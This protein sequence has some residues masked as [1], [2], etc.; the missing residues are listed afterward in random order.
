MKS[1][2][3]EYFKMVCDYNDIP[4]EK[5]ETLS[6]ASLLDIRNPFGI[7]GIEEFLQ[8]LEESREKKSRIL[9]FGDYD[10]D[11]VCAASILYKALNSVHGGYVSYYNPLYT[12]GYGIQ[13]KHVERFL[14][15][16][17]DVFITVDNGVSAHAAF[18]AISKAGK[19]GA[20]ID[21]H[22]RL[23]T[24]PP[25]SADVIINPSDSILCGAQLAYLVSRAIKKRFLNVDEHDLQD[26]TLAGIAAQS[27]YVKLD[28]PETRSW[29]KWAHYYVNYSNESPAVVKMIKSLKEETFV[30]SDLK[31]VG[32]LLNMA[33]RHTHVDPK[34]IVSATLCETADDPQLKDLK[35]LLQK[36]E[37]V[38][39]KTGSLFDRL[40][41]ETNAE[42]GFVIHKFET[43]SELAEPEGEIAGWLS[44][45]YKCPIILF[46]EHGDYIN[47]Q[48]RS[49]DFFS[50]KKY[51]EEPEIRELAVSIGGHPQ[52]IGGTI[53]ASRMEQ[54]SRKT[55]ELMKKFIPEPIN[56]KSNGKELHLRTITPKE[57]FYL[58][59][60]S[61]P[62]GNAF[63]QPEFKSTLKTKDSRSF[64]NGMRVITGDAAEDGVWDVTY[65]LDE[66]I[67]DGE[68]IGI[69]I[70]Q[71][72]PA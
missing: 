37:W 25:V 4:D 67:C 55:H 32:S 29:V 53:S 7:E 3:K 61:A 57:A 65:K 69:K 24:L 19:K 56:S 64:I 44:S 6:K 70:T 22:L 12:E 34:V 68:Q 43:Y 62:F 42:S 46:R 14:D 72:S 45:H 28:T 71:K 1:N 54:F 48:G 60:K 2:W 51:I 11:G 49:P 16:G 59:R 31:S 13:K 40:R 38:R 33:K 23:E 21:H 52:A 5:V 26:L 9:I 8:L 18:D 63:F 66:E 10:T 50:F 35:S 47:L 30:T 27:D 20:V 41:E 36:S 17:I 39:E 15:E 58:S